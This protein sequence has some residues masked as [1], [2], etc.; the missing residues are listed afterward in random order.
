MTNAVLVM[1]FYD[2]DK[3]CGLSASTLD[4]LPPGRPVT[5]DLSSIWLD[6]PDSGSVATR[7][8]LPTRTTRMEVVLWSDWSSWTNTLMTGL[9][10][11]YTFVRQ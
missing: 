11:T 4:V 8:P 5:F 2:G 7:C 1:L 10:L 6:E 9:P 3:L